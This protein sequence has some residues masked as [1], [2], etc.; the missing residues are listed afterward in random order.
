MLYPG[1]VVPLAMFAFSLTICIWNDV[2]AK[3]RTQSV[4]A[5]LIAVGNEHLKIGPI[6]LL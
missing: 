4:I 2:I 6:A 5:V 1:S 3:T